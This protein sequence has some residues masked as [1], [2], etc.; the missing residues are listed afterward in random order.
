MAQIQ[1]GPLV[2]PV[3]LP[4]SQVSVSLSVP[5]EVRVRW[6]L[7]PRALLLLASNTP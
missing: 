3:A 7:Q 2:L 5:R 1:E 6:R 4:G